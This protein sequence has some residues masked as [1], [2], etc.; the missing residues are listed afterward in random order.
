MN[1]IFKLKG[2]TVVA[3]LL[4]SSA[5]LSGTLIIFTFAYDLF[6]KLTIFQLILL[7]IVGTMPVI[8]FNM[9]V[10]SI[11]AVDV[12]DNNKLDNDELT[13]VFAGIG[14]S[15]SFLSLLV[16]Y[17]PILMYLIIP[18]KFKEGLF[19]AGMIELFVI[20]LIVWFG[21]STKKT[22]IKL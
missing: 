19:C 8:V 10:I 16:F 15:A 5:L 12:D 2:L 9:F 17:F 13:N 18:M 21:K 3:L 22:D 1:E 7:S 6:F 4:L 14:F 11:A 20:L